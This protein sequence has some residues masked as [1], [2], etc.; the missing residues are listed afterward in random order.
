MMQQEFIKWTVQGKETS[1]L[2]ICV[3]GFSSDDKD[4]SGTYMAYKLIVRGKGERKIEG[5]E[6]ILTCIL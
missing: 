6:T 3:L 5:E 4:T 1:Y 2:F